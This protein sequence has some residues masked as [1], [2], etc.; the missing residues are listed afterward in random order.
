MIN[1]K[2]YGKSTVKV[3]SILGTVTVTVNG[4]YI[5]VPLPLPF[6]PLP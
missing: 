2:N 6:L 4:T 1:G 5:R 3:R